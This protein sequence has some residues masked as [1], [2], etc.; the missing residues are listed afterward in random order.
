MTVTWLSYN[1]RIVPHSQKKLEPN[2]PLAAAPPHNFT[3]FR[4]VPN[5]QKTRTKSATCCTIT[6]LLSSTT[7]HRYR[8]LGLDI[9]SMPSV[10]LVK[11]NSYDRPAFPDCGD[12]IVP[13]YPVTWQ[14]EYKG[15]SCSRTQFP[16]RL[17][18]AITVYKSRLTGPDRGT[19]TGPDWTDL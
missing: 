9:S 6:T 8:D 15:I 3:H 10:I 14:F 1:F 17:A 11:F 4:T 12:G 2:Q 7:H 5:S 13:I 18:Y 16:L 19:G